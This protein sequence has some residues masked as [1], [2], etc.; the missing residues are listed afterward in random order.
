MSRNRPRPTMLLRALLYAGLIMALLALARK[1]FGSRLLGTWNWS[2]SPP[3]IETV[4]LPTPQP[5]PSPDTGQSDAGHAAMPNELPEPDGDSAYVVINENIPF[6]SDT[7]K[8]RTDAFEEYSAL[9]HLGRCDPAY[10]NV[11][12]QLMPTESRDQVL[13]VKPS[14]WKQALYPDVVD[15]DFL[16]NRCHLIA[17]QLAGE[18]SNERNLITGTRHL[19]TVGMLD[20]E[21]DVADYVRRTN[22]HVLY[23]VTPMFKDDELVARGVLI[24]AYSVED[25][26]RLQMCVYCF[27]VQPGIGI[28]YATGASWLLETG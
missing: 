6:F 28:D 21:N 13:D 20:F 27:N 23:R 26:G 4:A 5:T 22:G 15:K 10:A 12:R 25:K 9:D 3:S 24:E 11:C 17:Y 2:V 8:Q 1:S 14:G 7:D 19:N 18:N 16:W